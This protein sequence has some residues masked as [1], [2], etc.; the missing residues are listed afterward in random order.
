MQ[1]VIAII[2]KPSDCQNCVFSFCKY[3]LPLSTYRKGYCC[4]LQEPQN[5]VVEDFDYEAEVHLSNCPL[6]EIPTEREEKY[7]SDV[8]LRDCGFIDG[9]NACLD[10]IVK[11][12]VDNAE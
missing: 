2:D 1:K 5:R 7:A 8:G 10:E 9:W 6:R 3:S 4:T 11:G 12:G